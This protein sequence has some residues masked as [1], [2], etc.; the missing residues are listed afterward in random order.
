MSKTLAL[1]IVLVFLTVST[2]VMPLPAKASSKTI[3]VPDEYPTVSSAIE[4]ASDGDTVF[5]KTAF[6]MNLL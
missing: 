1:A 4:N 6:T 2:I 3:V 5:V